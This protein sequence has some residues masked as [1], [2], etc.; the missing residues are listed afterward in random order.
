[1]NALTTSDLRGA[2]AA[3][4][5]SV[6]SLDGA[7]QSPDLTFDAWASPY[8]SRNRYFPDLKFTDPNWEIL[9]F[10]AESRLE[11]QTTYVKSVCHSISASPTTTIRYLQNLEKLGH[12]LLCA[13]R[14]DSRRTIVKISD[15]AFQSFLHWKS[16]E[17]RLAA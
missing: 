17:F 16:A 13:D 5:E 10:L 9:F 14:S 6:K 7:L 1:M 4:V 12:L 15:R 2:F 3:F 8:R 11:G